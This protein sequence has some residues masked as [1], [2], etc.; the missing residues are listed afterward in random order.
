MTA[1]KQI[2]LT[3]LRALAAVA[4]S[5]SLTRAAEELGYSEP[6]VHLQLA[7][8]R[9][10]VGGPVVTHIH[11]RME[12]TELGRRILPHARD[13]IGAVDQIASEAAQVHANQSHVLRVGVGRGTGI[14]LFP[15]VADIIGAKMPG[16]SFELSVIPGPEM[17]AALEENRIDILITT[18]I[19]NLI[20]NSGRRAG[21]EFVAVPLLRYEWSFV[22]SP[23]LAE[24]V[25]SGALGDIK[26]LLPEWAAGQ[27]KPAEQMLAGLEMRTHLAVATHTEAAKSAALASQSLAFVP[28][29][30]ARHELLSG[31]LV[32]CLTDL[33]PHR[34]YLHVGHRRPARHSDVHDFIMQLRQIRGVLRELVTVPHILPQR[35]PAS[36]VASR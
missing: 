12:L 24:A 21:D 14:Y 5:G 25:D 3:H 6:A 13:A 19:A 32:T 4:A 31:E 11:G 26:V 7:A 8:L 15:R 28:R 18:N 1:A 35:Y 30:T 9:R 23:D 2:Q 29:Y 27:I 36:A 22:A 34:S 17:E 10:S 16:T 20:R 33:T